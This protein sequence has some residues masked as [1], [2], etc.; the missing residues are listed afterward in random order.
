MIIKKNNE[1]I[2]GIRKSCK[3]AAKS[4]EFIDP[5]VLPGVTTDQLN[6]KINEFIRDNGAIPAPLNYHGF[7]KETCISV[8]E[9]VC[10]GIPSDRVLLEGDILNIDVTTILDGYYGDTSKMYAVGI[11]S[12]EAKELMKITKESLYK[13]IESISPGVAFNNIGW[14]IT[15]FLINSKY[16]IVDKFV[17]HGC[18]LSFHEDPKICHY[19]D[20]KFKDFGQKI[21][22]GMTFTIEPMINLGD[23]DCLILE[24]KWTAI[25]VDKKL[26]AQYEHMILC[27]ETGYEIL[28]EL[29]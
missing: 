28:T 24:D 22:P 4:L 1:Q 6:Q 13:G 2:E 26:S 29:N 8:N 5:F 12:E 14:A 10:H 3:L 11:V 27:T 17:G 15:D 19:V 20:K 16:S 21:E 7:P 18:G 25:T 9:V 23:A